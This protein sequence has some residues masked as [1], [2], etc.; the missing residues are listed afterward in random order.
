[1]IKLLLLAS[2]LVLAGVGDTT[3]LDSGT[4]VV[5]DA[6][7]F[8]RSESFEVLRRGAAGYT[9]VNTITSATG[10]YRVQA[11]FD[12][13]A[14]WRAVSAQG[15]GLYDGRAVEIT[16]LP[17]RPIATIRVAPLQD[18]A[19]AAQQLGARCDPDCLLDM[20]P[21]I[22][23]MFVMTRHYDFSRGGVQDFRWV[24][25]DLDQRRTANGNIAALSYAGERELQRA[26]GRTLRVRHFT[27]VESIPLPQGGEFRMN[28]DLWTDTDHAPIAFRARSPNGRPEGIVGVRS[29]HEDL[30]PALLMPTGAGTAAVQP[31]A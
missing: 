4:F 27:F 18:A 17:T 1:M 21:S 13:D 20:S 28:F 30:R 2:S 9:I 22:L 11:R 5:R 14:G 15:V 16:L 23:P 29:S 6:G 31:G 12:F 26:D 19:P 8:S 7:P 3:L 10:R 24:G 25:Q